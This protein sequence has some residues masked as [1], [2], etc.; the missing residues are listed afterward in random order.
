MARVAYLQASLNAPHLI[1]RMHGDRALYLSWFLRSPAISPQQRKQ[2]TNFL[3]TTGEAGNF[4]VVMSKLTRHLPAVL[5]FLRH[6]LQRRA[7]P[8]DAGLRGHAMRAVR[9]LHRAGLGGDLDYRKWMRFPL[10]FYIFFLT[11][12]P[13]CQ[14]S[15]KWLYLKGNYYWRYT[16]FWLPWLWEEVCNPPI[17]PCPFYIPLGCQGYGKAT[18]LS[19]S[20]IREYLWDGR[21]WV[22]D[23]PAVPRRGPTFFF[24][25]PPHHRLW[26]FPK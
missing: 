1:R 2:N 10:F 4:A 18:F 19:G 12:P 16:H 21:F 22:H 17:F 24:T 23:F 13:L 3:E 6:G 15:G 5:R 9:A 26:Y 20:Y 8:G 7:S 25:E 14:G 11:L